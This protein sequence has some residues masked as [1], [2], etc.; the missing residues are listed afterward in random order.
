MGVPGDYLNYGMCSR[1][2]LAGHLVVHRSKL[3]EVVERF[4]LCDVCGL[5]PWVQ[6]WRNVHRLHAPPAE[7]VEELKRPLV[8]TSTL[9]AMLEV[10]PDTLRKK[11]REKRL[12]APQP[13][14]L[15]PR[16]Q[17]WRY[18]EIK[19]IID[20]AETPTLPFLPKEVGASIPAGAG[21]LGE[22]SAKPVVPPM[23]RNATLDFIAS[24]NPTAGGQG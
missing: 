16:S 12:R 1:R 13:I 7:L 3:G 21:E 15:G 19:A 2:D 5:Y 8:A 17:R 24:L 4:A 23:A 11:M 18:F 9:A 10:R 20:N 14:V 22:A 6:I